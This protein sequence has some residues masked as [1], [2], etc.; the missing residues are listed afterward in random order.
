MGQAENILQ[1][2]TST[3][4]S[5]KMGFGSCRASSRSEPLQFNNASLAHIRVE[6][7]EEIVGDYS[8][9]RGNKVFQVVTL[10]AQ[11]FAVISTHFGR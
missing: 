8:R 11:G 7:V 9:H 1:P 6:I 10:D 5:Q 2:T 4:M 3:N